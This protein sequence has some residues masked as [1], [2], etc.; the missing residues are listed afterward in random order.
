[1]V[2]KAYFL[3]FA[4]NGILD[5]VKWMKLEE[6][7][8][9][10][11]IYKQIQRQ[12]KQASKQKDFTVNLVENLLVNHVLFCTTKSMT[13]STPKRLSV[14]IEKMILVQMLNEQVNFEHGGKPFK[15][16]HRWYSRK[17]LSL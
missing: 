4:R 12:R 6:E 3:G 16:L 15:G 8:Y 11:P 2:K 13:D 5:N 1:M 14:F 7:M 9:G 10:V 17:P